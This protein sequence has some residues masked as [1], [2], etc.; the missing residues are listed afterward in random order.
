[1]AKKVAKKCQ[2][3]DV[4][5]VKTTKFKIKDCSVNLQRLNLK[6]KYFH[7]YWNLLK[8]GSSKKPQTYGENLLKIHIFHYKMGD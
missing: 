4:Q 2:K 5:K 8:F 1:M 7:Q 6:G 3:I